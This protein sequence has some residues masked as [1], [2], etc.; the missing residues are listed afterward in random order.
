MAF[1]TDNLNAYD[2]IKSFKEILA[3]R[4]EERLESGDLFPA[5][6]LEE[7]VHPDTQKEW[8][9]H[10]AGK[11]ARQKELDAKKK[12]DDEAKAKKGSQSNKAPMNEEA[13][14]LD[15]H[16]SKDTLDTDWTE[17]GEAEKELVI[18]LRA[19]GKMMGSDEGAY[20]SGVLCLTFKNKKAVEDF[21]TALEEEEQVETYEIEVERNDYVEGC[22]ED[23]EYDFGDVFL[24]N[25]FNF[26][27]YIYI[28]ADLVMLP[29]EELE[30]GDEF[31]WDDET[32]NGF[33]TEVRRKIKVNF[34]GKK[35]I[36]MQCSPGFKWNASMK[37]CKKITGAQVAVMRKAM[38]RA[39]LTKKSLGQSFKARVV[40]KAKKAN[41]FRK[42]F[43]LR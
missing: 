6:P 13:E 27:V 26:N 4:L 10:F 12:K 35:R 41:R 14:Q 25:G 36:K 15:E 2:F 40:R 30:V 42:S 29:P 28:N 11:D 5:L 7:A 3:D 20:A 38:R 8:D 21:V 32:G 39:V 9:K 22:V 34:R 16:V 24:D 17:M 1:D 23:K 37:T 18:K 43:G 31:E 19:T 33:L